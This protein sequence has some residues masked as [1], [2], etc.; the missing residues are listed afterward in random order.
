MKHI[1]TSILILISIS[2][3]AQEV[4]YSSILIPKELK[5]NANSVVR[6][7]QIQIEIVSRKQMVVKKTKVVTVLNN[8][9][10]NNIDA[11][12]Y[13]N[14][15]TKVKTIEAV[16]YNSM[17]LE[18]KKIKRKDFIDQSVAD[19][20][21][22]YNDDR[23]LYLDYTPTEFPFTIVY[24]SE[25]ETSNTAFIPTWFPI[26]DFYESVEKSSIQIKFLSELG[27]KYK[28]KNLITDKISKQE[29]KNELLY[30]AIN[31]RA[32][33]FEEYSPSFKKIQPSVLFG[34]DSFFLEGIE[35]SAKSWDEFGK[36]MYENLL[37]DTEQIPETTKQKIK[38]IIGEEQDPIKKARIIYKYV[39]DKSRYISIQ[40]GIG[41]WKPMLANDV[42]KLGYGDCKAL[43]NY[44]RVLLK[45]VG[46]ESFYTIIYAGN[47]KN[48]INDDFVSVQGN[49]AILTIP[50]NNNYV[51]LECTSQT[52]PFGFN[53]DFTDDRFALVVTSDGGKIIKTND[54]N[55]KKSAQMTN[56][57]YSIDEKGNFTG[58]VEIKSNGIQYDNKYRIE[59]QSQ[60]KKDLH[61][62]ELF[63]WINN[64][65]I[66][67]SEIIN[68]KETIEF[69][70]KLMV[71]ADNYATST[72]EIM[73][74]PINAFNRSLSLPKRYKS[75]ENSFEI[76]RGFY[77]EDEVDLNLPNGYVVD[78]KPTD[79]I[80]DSKF[81]TYKIKL[82]VLTPYK[83]KYKRSYLLNNG[84]YEKEDYEEFRKFHEQINRNDNLKIVLKKSI[85]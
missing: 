11:I 25:I 46:V 53:G 38:S 56:G 18:I 67:K 35:G 59:S 21:S 70:E 9:G 77:D 74:F 58:V 60:D 31:L 63:S 34:L 50:V 76:S 14:K 64:I 73:M 13:Y 27:F 43:T 84:I 42:D 4:K 69:Q 75:R 83:I 78:S 7:Q 6:N 62:K 8:K 24:N 48:D 12:E 49:H 71:S 36:W 15:S 65:K 5:E 85:N 82:E 40:L 79:V 33:K 57:T 28:E 29:T 55:S 44:T 81:G 23:K 54:L 1:F 20:F 39:Q 37:K 2:I 26:D 72:N 3:F 41:G 51:F 32:T 10:I 45:E 22:I 16:V 66:V 61:Y 30:N 80:I 17:G 52:S 19:G 47:D 68:N